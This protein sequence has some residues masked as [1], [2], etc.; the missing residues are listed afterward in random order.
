MYRSEGIPLPEFEIPKI[1]F[2]KYNN[3]RLLYNKNMTVKAEGL[4][5]E[6]VENERGWGGGV[7]GDRVGGR[8]E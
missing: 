1:Y 5:E 4:K 7:E 3:N 6:G 2:E 8:E